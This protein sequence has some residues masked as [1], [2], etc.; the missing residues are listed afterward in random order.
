[1]VFEDDPETGPRLKEYSQPADVDYWTALWRNPDPRSY[2]RAEKGH[3][4]HQLRDTFLKW[5]RPGARVLEA[6]CGL[7]HFT[8]AANA[9]GYR[10][11][12]L[13]WSEPTVESLRSRYPAIQW[14]VGDVRELQFEDGEFDAV[15]SP[16][17]CEHFEEGPNAI[18][19]ETARVLRPGGVAVISTP[20]FN[21]WLQQRPHL[22]AN[23]K[24]G[25]DFYQYAFTPSGLSQLL[26]QLRFE[27]LNVRPYDSLTTLTRHAN[28]K[29]PAVLIKPFSLV[30][31]YVPRVREWGS[32]CLW[33]ALRR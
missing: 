1:V 29:V 9:R 15:Y 27:V 11:E 18:L 22:L 16:G 21:E 12:G 30:L 33:V 14:H 24:Y 28:V 2:A 32:S 4:P 13:D 25:T 23:N 10:A 20:C 7:G 5:V 17:V 26:A 8:V 3:L 31:D 19:R 6:G